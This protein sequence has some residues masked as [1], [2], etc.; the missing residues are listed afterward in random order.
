MSSSE[1]P[2]KTGVGALASTS[3]SN[4]PLLPCRCHPDPEI[5]SIPVTVPATCTCQPAEQE[6]RMEK[7]LL[8]GPLEPPAT[9]PWLTGH[10][11]LCRGAPTPGGGGRGPG[12]GPVLFAVMHEPLRCGDLDV[13]VQ[14]RDPLP[15]PLPHATGHPDPPGPIAPLANGVAVSPCPCSWWASALSFL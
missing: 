12:R 15:L 13:Y 3:P 4:L 5:L 8:P 14:Q 10:S 6:R 11:T 2:C 7:G 1:P 9:P